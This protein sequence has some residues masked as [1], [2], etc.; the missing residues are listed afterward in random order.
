M[1]DSSFVDFLVLC[2]IILS[3]CFAFIVQKADE[4]KNVR[5]LIGKAL[6]L[7]LLS[8]LLGLAVYLKFTFSKMSF[9]ILQG[10]FQAD[11]LSAI[12]GVVLVLLFLIIYLGSSFKDSIGLKS[13]ELFNFLGLF[14]A[15]NFSHNLI[16]I[17]VF[18]ELIF[19]KAMQTSNYGKKLFDLRGSKV[20]LVGL[21]LILGAIAV[22]YGAGT[23]A[24]IS[25][26][27]SNASALFS[28]DYLFLIGILFI[29]AGLLDI[30]WSLLRTE[31]KFFNLKTMIVGLC[32]LFT[33]NK[34]SAAQFFSVLGQVQI[35]IQWAFVLILLFTAFKSLQVNSFKGALKH[36]FSNSLVLSLIFTLPFMF[37]G[38]GASV[39]GLIYLLG[40][41]S[42]HILLFM[43][44]EHFALM[45][46]GELLVDE[47]QGLGEKAPRKTFLLM[48][49]VILALSFPLG[50]GVLVMSSGVK[51][52]LQTGFYW[53]GFWSL[54]STA[55]IWFFCFQ[56][57]EKM[58]L[59]NPNDDLWLLWRTKEV[60]DAN[61]YQLVVITAATVALPVLGLCF[62]SF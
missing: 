30:L 25:F 43:I 33:I 20:R 56:L 48:V 27:Q 5:P 2:P 50:A 58:Y 4:A 39:V 9:M 38:E 42:G 24:T 61:G 21:V 31:Y 26:L 49:A 12:S 8:C 46:G 37:D 15:L 29:I 55:I 44:G 57:L 36:L 59:Q 13:S 47:L 1:F 7:T 45:K 19:I 53:V 35:L 18:S 62:F 51:L 3:F 28:A 54:F 14:L 6:G 34:Y 22:N 17:F 32:F 60:S 52:I 41:F 16:L 23:S 10:L 11:K 40:A